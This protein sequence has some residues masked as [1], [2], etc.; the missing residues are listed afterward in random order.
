MATRLT[1]KELLEGEG[2]TL[3]ALAESC[4]FGTRHA[5]AL[6][7]E[8]CEVEPDGVCPHGHPSFMIE[9]GII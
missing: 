7:S 2:C 3:E 9:A 6:C 5:P 1:M 8:H 4:M